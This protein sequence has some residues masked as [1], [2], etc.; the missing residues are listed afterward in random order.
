MREVWSVKSGVSNLHKQLM[1]NRVL[2]TSQL[3]TINDLNCKRFSPQIFMHK[4]SL[5]GLLI[6]GGLTHSTYR[7]RSFVEQSIYQQMKHNNV[8]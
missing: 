7:V 5:H 2:K 1:L 8:L 6:K 3:H 4:M